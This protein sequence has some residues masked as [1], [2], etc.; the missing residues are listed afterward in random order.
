MWSSLVFPDHTLLRA[1]RTNDYSVSIGR[2]ASSSVHL[3]A[4]RG[5]YVTYLDSV[6]LPDLTLLFQGT[7]P[8]ECTSYQGSTVPLLVK[9]LFPKGLRVAL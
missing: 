1:V 5:Q 3:N 6:R 7:A 9:A 2:C 8:I 4:R